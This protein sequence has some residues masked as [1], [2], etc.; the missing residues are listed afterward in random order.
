[1]RYKIKVFIKAGEYDCVHLTRDTTDVHYY[2]SLKAAKDTCLAIL[3]T[4]KQFKGNCAC[5]YD[6]G[7]MILTT[8][9]E[10][11]YWIDYRKTKQAKQMYMNVSTESVAPYEDWY[12]TNNKGIKVN[13]VDLGEVIPVE[14]DYK[15]QE[16]FILCD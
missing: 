15:E 12:Y 13:A 8:N 9:N 7:K 6:N 3:N 5:I 10:I 1:M 11:N 16:W 2:D 4:F 14:W